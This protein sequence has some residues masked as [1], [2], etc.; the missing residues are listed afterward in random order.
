MRDVR[1]KWI[2]AAIVSAFV[3]TVPL[4]DAAESTESPRL[5]VPDVQDVTIKTRRSFD[6]PGSTVVTDLLY[7]KGPWQRREEILEFPK[8]TGVGTV[9]PYVTIVR[10]DERRVIQL[11]H[12]ARTFASSKIEMISDSLRRVRSASSSLQTSSGATVN[13]T[14]DV[15]ETG[16]RRQ[17][18]HHVA[19]HVI[20]TTKTDAA[21]EAN[22]RSGVLIQDAWYID[23]PP[24]GCIDWG[25]HPPM[26]SGSLVRSGSTPDRVHVHR[27]GTTPL[28]RRCR[29]SVAASIWPGPTRSRIG[30]GIIWKS[31]HR[32][33]TTTSGAGG[34]FGDAARSSPTSETRA[35][36]RKRVPEWS[37]QRSWFAAGAERSRLAGVV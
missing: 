24:A 27:G 18:G 37:S 2:P 30:C 17:L 23:V 29:A 7:L 10:C 35:R 31:S 28:G 3:V 9:R 1:L 5:V 26:L 11:N 33:H 12:A 32:G 19:H 22:V 8:N 16:E 4:P 34:H 6:A 20:T 14:I 25:D 15:V 21:P 36:R 13:I